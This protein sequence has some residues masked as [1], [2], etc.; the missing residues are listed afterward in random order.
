MA[1]K[2]LIE[3]VK[4]TWLGFDLETTGISPLEDLP[5][6]VGL[7]NVVGNGLEVEEFYVNPEKPIS[8][9]AFQV[10]GISDEVCQSQGVSLAE[11]AN[12]ICEKIIA[13]EESDIPV[14][15]MNANFDV[16]IAS[17][18]FK[19]AGIESPSWKTLI[20]PLVVD[21]HFDRYRKGKRQLINLCEHYNVKTEPLHS[22]GVDAGAAAR[23]A[24]KIVETLDEAKSILLSNM[25]NL[26]KSWHRDWANNFD[27]Y[28]KGQGKSGLSEI[29]FNWPFRQ[30]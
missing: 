14:V 24:V 8:P 30:L 5:V 29:E 6:Q 20:D 2:T 22:A 15:V 28:L 4:Y 21:R 12:K 11:A 19:S 27:S 18:I 17:R 25:F 26:Q 10:H 9:G 1:E 3:L 13:A 23:V 16:T 7:A